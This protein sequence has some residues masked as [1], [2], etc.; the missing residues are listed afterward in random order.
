MLKRTFIH[1]PGVGHRGEAHFWRQ[2]LTTWE[3]FLASRRIRG[4]SQ[5]RLEWLK[6]ELTESLNRVEDAAYFAARLQA[7][8]HWRLFNH[9]RPRTAYLDIETTGTTWPGLLVTVVGLYDGENMRQ[10]VQGYNL[11]KF[12]EVISEFDL[13]VTFNGTQFDLPVLRAYFPE[14]CL[15][16][17]HVDLRFLLA[18]LG[19]KGGL[20]RIEPRFGIHRPEAVNGMDGYMAVLLW[21]RYQRGDKGA[22][23]LLLKYNRED[24]V[25]LEVLMDAAFRMSRERLIPSSPMASNLRSAALP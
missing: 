2:G 16:P 15:P 21:E 25:N 4:L 11:R 6:G 22:L 14:L 8:E 7:G 18:R 13:L 23:D 24:V 1:L 3:D 5:P 9:F 19:Y 10:F 12:P 20:K 17:A